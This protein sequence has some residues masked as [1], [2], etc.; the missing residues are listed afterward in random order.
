MAGQGIA[1]ARTSLYVRLM[2]NLPP[3]LSRRLAAV[4][5]GQSRDAIDILI[6]NGM[7]TDER[8]GKWGKIPTSQV[9]ALRGRP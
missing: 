6:E 2:N 9:E 7:L 1:S 4:L 8:R 5:T 3:Y